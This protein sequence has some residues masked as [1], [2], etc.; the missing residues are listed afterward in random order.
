MTDTSPSLG[1]H[2]ELFIKNE[3]VSGRYGSASEVARDALCAMEERKIRLEVLRALGSIGE[4]FSCFRIP[5]NRFQAV[6]L[7]LE[8]YPA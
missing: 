4:T 2:W 1:E 8:S 3:V 6:G 7:P 5:A